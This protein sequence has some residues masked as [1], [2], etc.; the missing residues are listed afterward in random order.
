MKKILLYTFISLMWMGCGDDDKEGNM[1]DVHF[2]LKFEDQP[3]VMLEEYDLTEDIKIKFTRV[4]FYLSDFILQG[5]SDYSLT[6]IDYFNLTNAHSS[7]SKASNGLEVTYDIPN[8]EYTGLQTGLGVPSDLNAMVPADFPSSN[9]LSFSGEYWSGWQSYVFAKI[10]GKMDT[11][12]DGI[13]EENI[14]LHTGGDIAF[15][16]LTWSENFSFSGDDHYQVTLYADIY[17][18]MNMEPMYDLIN[19]PRIHSADQT[20][21]VI[22]ISDRWEASFSKE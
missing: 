10:E 16:S 7:L 21:L 12:G 4:S 9:D 18:L 5:D 1:L 15:R 2:K 17:D 3:L 19:N 14:A 6:N 20:D 8:G 22:D 13:F 11:D